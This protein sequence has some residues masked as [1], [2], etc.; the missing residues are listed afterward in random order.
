V[1]ILVAD[2]YVEVDPSSFALMGSDRLMIATIDRNNNVSEW[3][4]LK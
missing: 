4:S 3:V 1:D 2:K